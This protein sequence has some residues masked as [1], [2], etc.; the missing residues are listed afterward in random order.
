MRAVGIK[1]PRAARPES[2]VLRVGAA[3][4]AVSGR[5]T[6]RFAARLSRLLLILGERANV[7]FCDSRV[8]ARL[9]RR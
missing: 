5:I 8:E 7:A 4:P 1:E 2:R 3:P 9:L 6:T